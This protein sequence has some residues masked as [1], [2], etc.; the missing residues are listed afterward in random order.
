MPHPT[1]SGLENDPK[2]APA[3]YSGRVTS[4][5]TI[6]NYD[7]NTVTIATDSP[8]AGFVLLTDN[9]YPGWVATVD[10]KPAKLYRADYTLRA[11]PVPEGKHMV[12]FR[13]APVTFTVGS[14]TTGI[15]ALVSLAFIVYMHK[16]RR[17]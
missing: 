13:Y 5:A 11:V 16:R 8:V 17:S 3:Q 12:I 9:Y 10:G 6:T 4:S 15:G 7:L 2:V 14:I 1:L